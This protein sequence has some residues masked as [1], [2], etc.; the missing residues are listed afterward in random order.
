MFQE[1]GNDFVKTREVK[2]AL[3]KK[4]DVA[5]LNSL[6]L[7]C[8]GAN[9]STQRRVMFYFTLRYDGVACLQ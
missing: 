2:A 3:L 9:A 7:H 4:G 6:C 1:H 5:I 8:G